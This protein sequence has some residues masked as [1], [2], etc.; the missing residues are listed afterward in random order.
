MK[1]LKIL[2]YVSL[3]SLS[4]LLSCKGDQSDIVI[5]I[6]VPIHHDDFEYVVTHFITSTKI[7]LEKDTLMAHGVFYLVTFQVKNEARK[8]NH[9]WNNSIAYIKDEAGKVFENNVQ[10]QTKLNAFKNFGWKEKYVTSCQSFDTTLFIFDLPKDVRQP[11]LM[12]RGEMLMGDFFDG[13]KYLR[14]KIRLY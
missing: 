10:L 4:W 3:I 14:T 8:V 2:F 5:G 1:P 6:N 7:P 12:V 11:Y 9:N 13:N